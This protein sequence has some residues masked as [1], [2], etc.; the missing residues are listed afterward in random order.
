M[1][2][3]DISS[4]CTKWRKFIRAHI[5]GNTKLAALKSLSI[6]ADDMRCAIT[7]KNTS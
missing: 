5:D 6:Y 4:G 7:N 1:D 3:G 2:L